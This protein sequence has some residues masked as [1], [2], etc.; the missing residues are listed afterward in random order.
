MEVIMK[1]RLLFIYNPNAGTGK[2]KG[3]LSDIL[4][5]FS[6]AGYEVIVYPTKCRMDARRC[7]M[8]YAKK[9]GCD[10]IVCAG[11]D[12]TLNEVAGGMMICNKNIPIGYIPAGTTND[13]GYSLRIPKNIISAAEVAA[14]GAVF[15]C[16]IGTM[17]GIY[18]IYTVAFGLFSNVSYETP[19]NMKNVLGRAAYILSGITKLASVKPYQIRVEY[20]DTIVEE[21]FILGII[22]NSDSIGGFR[23]LTGKDVMFDDGLFEMLL[24]KMPKNLLD[25]NGIIYELLS[26][27]I[28]NRHICYARVSKVHITSD[29]ELPWALDGEAGGNIQDAEII[30][31]KQAVRYICLKQN[32]GVPQLEYDSEKLFEEA[33]RKAL[34]EEALKEEL[35]TLTEEIDGRKETDILNQSD[36]LKK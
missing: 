24:V 2:I 4:E 29:S 26:G 27:E 31:H 28:G 11:G 8:E 3:K 34:S 1:E 25:L 17:N 13:F 9:D 21:E 16:D 22:S 20:E 10:R 6:I 15:Q 36:M 32:Q 30:I 35:D 12:G 14:T 7:A 19:Q 18:F 23:G 5:I 33:E